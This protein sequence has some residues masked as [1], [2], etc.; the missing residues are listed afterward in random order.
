MLVCNMVAGG[1]GGSGFF[2]GPEDSCCS[3]R[4]TTS[5]SFK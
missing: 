2:A 1:T 4:L 3:I 5:G